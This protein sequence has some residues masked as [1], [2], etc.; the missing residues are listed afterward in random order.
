MKALSII[1]PA[2]N[3]SAFIEQTLDSIFE[4]ESIIKYLDVIVVNDGSTDDTLKKLKNYEV[5]FPDSL[6]IID[7]ENGG[8][9]SG[10]NAGIKV[11]QGKYL[12][13]IDGD[14]WLLKKGLEELVN[15]IINCEDYPDLIVNPY[16]KAWEGGEIETVD[17]HDIPERT[18]VDYS[19]VN[20]FNYTLPLHTITINTD[21]Y[22]SNRIQAIDEKISYDDMEYI[23][24]PVPYIK[25]ITFLAETVYVYRLGLAG[26]SMNPKQMLK[27]LPMHSKV[28]ETLATY[29][30]ENDSIF[31]AEAKYYYETEFVNTFATNCRLRVLS[32]T[33][34]KDI[35]QYV[36]KYKNFPLERIKNKR[37]K[38]LIMTNFSF[39]TLTKHFVR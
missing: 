1:I 33:S 36:S 14:D 30:Q 28:I 7:K 6:Q 10:I 34:K 9:G 2:Y 27:R 32:G 12:K 13:V 35:V 16:R 11:A 3:V 24:F 22:K 38:F 39:Y 15:Y 18:V 37:I 25:T 4:V 21:I 5:K 19:I 29:L 23:L 17:F 20:K 31:N 8:H 26:Q